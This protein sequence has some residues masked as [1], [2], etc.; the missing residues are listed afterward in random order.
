[1][2]S[3]PLQTKKHL[4]HL[5]GIRGLSAIYVVIYH[6]ILQY[7]PSVRD[8]WSYP[9]STLQKI[10][11]FPL[12]HGHYAVDVFIVLSGFSLMLS[13]IKNNH[14][15][16]G[17]YKA[18]FIRRIKRI[19]PPY[20][21]T[22]LLSLLL[23]H[24]AIGKKTNTQW[25]VSIPVNYEDIVLHIFLIHDFFLSSFAHI[26]HALWSIA[27]EFRIY[28]LFPTIILLWKWKGA[29]IA[30][31]GSIFCSII[32]FGGLIYCKQFNVNIN[33]EH[34]G[35]NPYIILF[36][37]GMLSAEF[38]F[39][40]S[41]VSK[42]VREAYKA[43][44]STTLLIFCSIILICF[45]YTKLLLQ[46]SNS[47]NSTIACNGILDILIGLT[48]S[49]ILF[50][51]SIVTHVDKQTLFFVKA[52]SWRPLV[53]VGTFSFSLY[54]IHPLLLQ[55]VSQ[56]L[57]GPVIVSKATQSYTLILIGPVISIGAAYIFY[58]AFERPF[59]QPAIKT[60]ELIK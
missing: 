6:A 29:F 23:I 10:L 41:I 32:I 26:N 4:S 28:F 13:V 22:V 56:Y 45:V 20:Y 18:F 42:K 51:F 33:V 14:I 54:L 48:F 53:F 5:D 50:M 60:S 9:L 58:L 52:L 30:F 2:I 38:S 34:S 59:I 25:D 46:S 55:L 40:E 43:F 11:F 44:P 17:G 36:T 37:T 21:F 47:A 3:V 27:V 8:L 24:F 49:G 16:K 15:I 35:V 12:K 39:S 31:L 1:M 7:Y 57:I 19:I